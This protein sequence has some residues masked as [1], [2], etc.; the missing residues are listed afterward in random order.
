MDAFPRLSIDLGDDALSHADRLITLLH[1]AEVCT[2][3]PDIGKSDIE[4]A[5]EAIELAL[6]FA[7]PLAAYLLD[8]H[9]K[10]V[11]EEWRRMAPKS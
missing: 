1:A 11:A 7:K 5:N 4:T 10:L 9:N 3:G 6:G 2:R 8:I